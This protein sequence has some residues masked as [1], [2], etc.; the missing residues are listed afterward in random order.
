MVARAVGS[1]R[2]AGVPN[3]NFDLIYGLPHQTATVLCRT[4]EQCVAMKPD[5]IVLF[6]YAHVPWVAKNQRMIGGGI[7]PTALERAEQARAAAAALVSSGYTQIG[8]DH[9]ALPGDSLAIAGAAGCLHRNFQGYTSDNARTLIG[10][11][12]SAIGRTP[13]P[14]SAH[15]RARWLRE[16]YRSLAATF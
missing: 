8:I 10:I 5:R 3:I 1:F 15:G 2:T 7:L 4:V 6:G 13:R 14:K 9:F 16:S 11:G 12:A